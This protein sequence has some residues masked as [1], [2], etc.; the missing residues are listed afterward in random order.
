MKKIFIS[1][2]MYG[3]SEE[4]ILKTRQA[5][6]AEARKI[7]NEDVT[8]VD[9][10]FKEAH[11]VWVPAPQNVPEGLLGLYYL[12]KSLE[13]MAEAD[14]VYFCGGWEKARGCKIEQAAA[15]AYG[16]PRLYGDV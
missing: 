14:M 3:L 12:G 15:I 13:K 1:Q 11:D 10:Y 4:K 16:I 6:L 7:L 8:E 9:S 2:P 5:A